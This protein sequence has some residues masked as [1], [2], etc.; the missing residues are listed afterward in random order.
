MDIALRT[1][2][3]DFRRPMSLHALGVRRCRRAGSRRVSLGGFRLRAACA[4]AESQFGLPVCQWPLIRDKLL[5]HALSLGVSQPDAAGCFPFAL[6][7][8][9]CDRGEV[10]V[11]VH[12]SKDGSS[13]PPRLCGARFCARRDSRGPDGAAARFEHADV[14]SRRLRRPSSAASTVQRAAAL[15]FSEFS[16]VD[17]SVHADGAGRRVSRCFT[18]MRR[19]EI[20]V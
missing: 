14:A 6:L 20:R 1:S 10:D 9:N 15:P 7:F 12:P 17:R 8:L 2:N 13:F 5:M 16:A 18:P 19:P 3:C 11:N 4:E